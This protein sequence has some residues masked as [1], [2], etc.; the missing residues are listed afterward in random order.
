[1]DLESEKYQQAMFA[2]FRSEGWKSLVEELENL[3]AVV[4]RIEAVR[5]NDDLKFRQGQ[6]NV[7]AL[8]LNLPTEVE[9]I[10]SDAEN[11]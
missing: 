8:V 11:L 2:L 3:R 1:M 7:I 10:G 9:R 6:L 5:D 4:E